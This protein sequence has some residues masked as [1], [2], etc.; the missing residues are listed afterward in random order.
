VKALE[1]NREVRSTELNAS[2]LRRHLSSA[3]SGEG[4]FSRF[5]YMLATQIVTI[6]CG[7][8]YWTLSARLVMPHSVGI[9]SAALS[10]SAFLG[11]VGVLGIGSL[12]L[13]EL[14]TASEEQVRRVVSTGS[15]VAGACVG[16]LA[17]A[18]WALS[19]WLGPSLR[20]L[21]TDGLDGLLFVLGAATSTVGVVVDCAAIGLR[22][23]RAQLT[24]NTVMALGRL[25][26]VCVFVV[27]VSRSATSLLLAWVIS[28]TISILVVPKTLGL[29]SGGHT[30]FRARVQLVKYYARLALRH[31]VL[32]LAITSVSFF[33]P[34]VA[35]LIAEPRSLA[36]FTTA[37][38]VASCVLLPPALLAMSLFAEAA[39]D[40]DTLRLHIRRTLPVAFACC[41]AVLAVLEPLAPLVLQV[42]GSRYSAHGTAV[43]R[44]LLLG[45]LP[46]VLKDHYVAICR[47]RGLLREAARV[48]ALTTVLEIAGAAVGGAVG[49]LDGLC[50]GWVIAATIE[51]TGFAPAVFRVVSHRK[52]APVDAP[53]QAV[54]GATT[55]L[56]SER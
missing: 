28:N 40:E 30:S 31:H 43:L 49:G 54:S 37:Q 26:L 25:A 20:A 4:L 45:G 42:F 46:Y 16:L 15:A 7:V 11:A 38:L 56:L 13:V 34:F 35:A 2:L 39:G 51:C 10:S 29:R 3:L 22:R 44:L 18:A 5:G 24:R 6:V 12:L 48:V 23:G 52:H 21:G 8:A 1:V 27:L 14:R 55:S 33:L 19:P 36:Y 47:A 41:I 17:L 50:A 9:A 53:P 32:N